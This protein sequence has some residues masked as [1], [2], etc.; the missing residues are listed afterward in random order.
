MKDIS[1][2]RFF[3]S[4]T[5]L[6]FIDAIYLYGSRA[7]GDGDDWSDIDLAIYCPNAT[8]T[9]WDYVQQV[10]HTQEILVPIPAT[11]YD[12]LIEVGF[13]A[14]IDKDKKILFERVRHDNT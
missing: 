4:L 8:S 6:P 5:A 7:R 2:Y 9:Q 1:H 3:Q 10:L 11:R 13:K 12:T 14:Q